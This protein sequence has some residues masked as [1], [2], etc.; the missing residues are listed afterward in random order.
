MVNSYVD[1]VGCSEVI[2]A[3][4]HEQ[5]VHLY[6]HVDYNFGMYK[7]GVL[8]NCDVLEEG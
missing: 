8:T 3:L 2:N 5:P 1:V 7:S 6:N 4:L